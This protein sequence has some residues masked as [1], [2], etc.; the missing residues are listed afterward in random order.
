MMSG[1]EHHLMSISPITLPYNG[2]SKI[3]AV[4]KIVVK[5]TVTVLIVATTATIAVSL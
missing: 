4:A 5:T 2:K 1:I 3:R